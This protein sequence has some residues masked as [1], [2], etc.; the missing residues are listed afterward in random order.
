MLARV[1]MNALRPYVLTILVNPQAAEEE[2][3]A[4]EATLRSWIQERQGTVM[5]VRKELKRT[6]SYAVKHARLANLTA[7]HFQLPPQELKDLAEKLKRQEAVLRFGI[8]QKL[9]RSGE[10][11]TLK[12]VPTRT[13]EPQK[14][15]S[16]PKKEKVGLE[17]LDE[18]IEEILEEKVL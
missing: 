17:K 12:D 2:Q 8:Q 6:L 14:T 16:V 11:K 18:K 5:N 9:P 1:R 3:N 15:S 7:V 13:V 10:A 4:V